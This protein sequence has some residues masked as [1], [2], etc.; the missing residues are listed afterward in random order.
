MRHTLAALRELA[1]PVADLV[2]DLAGCQIPHEPHLTRGAEGAG[3]R[4]ARLRRHAHRVAGAVVRH[5][6]GLDVVTVGQ[7]EQRL[8]RLAVRAGLFTHRIHGRPGEGRGESFA[9]RLWQVGELRELG[10]GPVRGVTADLFRAVR[11]LAALAKPSQERGI[12]HV[13][14]RRMDPGHAFERT[15]DAQEGTRS[16]V[17]TSRK[18]RAQSAPVMARLPA[19]FTSSRRSQPP[20]AATCGTPPWI[21]NVP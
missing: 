14:D 8:S 6:H 18:P 2:D 16:R 17:V 13:A 12:A 7:T 5:E 10:R 19:G 11:G 21:S 9:E 1:L 4:A 20:P 3:H 15:G